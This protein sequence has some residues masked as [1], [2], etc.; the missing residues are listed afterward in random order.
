[1]N[2]FTALK[3]LSQFYFTS[4]Y[5]T[6]FHFT[7]CFLFHLFYQPYPSLDFVIPNYNSLPFT[8]LPLTFYFL[9]LSLPLSGFHF[10]N[11]SFENMRFTLGSPY[12]PFR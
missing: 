10:P 4:L 2:P 12:R 5:F 6:S 11:P 3:N 7:F 8:S 9:S 1:M